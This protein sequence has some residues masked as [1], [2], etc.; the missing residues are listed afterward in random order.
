MTFLGW[1]TIFGVAAILTAVALPL[2]R[3]MAH[4]FTGERTFLDP[5]LGGRNG[6]CIGSCASIRRRGRIG[7]R[8]PSV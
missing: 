2:G 4:V 8:M 6:S 7:R 1:V 3:Y 5:V